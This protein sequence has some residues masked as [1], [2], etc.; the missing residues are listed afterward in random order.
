[1]SVKTGNNGPEG[2]IIWV[3][4][5]FLRSILENNSNI[6][7]FNQASKEKQIVNMML[8]PERLQ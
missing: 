6:Q 1:M 3:H 5:E 4:G 7:A 8:R 2:Q